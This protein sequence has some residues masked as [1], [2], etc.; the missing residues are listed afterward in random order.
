MPDP[1][2]ADLKPGDTVIV[3][4]GPAVPHTAKVDE[5]APCGKIRVGERWYRPDGDEVN[6]PQW[7]NCYIEV[8]DG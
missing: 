6:R 7:S 2:L 1:T 5:R 4:D 3:H 8:M